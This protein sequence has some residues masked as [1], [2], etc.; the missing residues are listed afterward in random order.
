M[1]LLS[2]VHTS[3]IVLKS[4]NVA[5]LNIASEK[6]DTDTTSTGESCRKENKKARKTMKNNTCRL[7]HEEQINACYFDFL[8]RSGG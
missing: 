1:L 2:T 4:V 5:I 3:E 7:Q 6:N 8:L